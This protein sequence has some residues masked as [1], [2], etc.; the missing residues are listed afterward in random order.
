[1]KQQKMKL[2]IVGLLGLFVFA[3][4]I[5]L[6]MYNKTRQIQARIDDQVTVLIASK[7]I[8]AGEIVGA[9]A[10]GVVE[11]PRSTVTFQPPELGDIVGKYAVTDILEGEPMRTEKLSLSAPQ[12]KTMPKI[13]TAEVPKTLP[14]AVP[15]ADAVTDRMS[16]PL[17]LFQNVD[18]TLK[19][20]D[21]IDIISIRPKQGG[22]TKRIG[23]VDVRYV[24]LNVAVA[25]FIANGIW[26]DALAVQAEGVRRADTILLEIT[27]KQ[28]GNFLSLYYE[29]QQINQMRPYND[30]KSNTGH[31]WMVRCGTLDVAEEERKSKMLVGARPKP[32]KRYIRKPK[33]EISYEN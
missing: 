13:E 7:S 30:G 5:A 22:G 23:D 12:P 1:M 17:R 10:L 9:S 18:D 29:A 33:V 24:A 15:A 11:L 16:I 28:I 8:E 19:E 26:Q 2:L 31:L 4:M 6:L 21:R 32:V 3:S 27:P 14:V 20:G 25:G